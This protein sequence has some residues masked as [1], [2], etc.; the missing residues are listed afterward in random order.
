M[1]ASQNLGVEETVDKC[2]LIAPFGIKNTREKRK[3]GGER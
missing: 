3:N 2:G 1:S